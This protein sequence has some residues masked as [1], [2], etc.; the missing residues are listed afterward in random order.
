MGESIVTEV[1]HSF[2]IVGEPRSKERPRLNRRTG[3]VY[4]PAATVNAE[5]EVAAAFGHRVPFDSAVAVDLRFYCFSKTRRDLDNLVKLVLD[6]L[7]GIA[8]TD[9]YQVVRITARR[10]QVD[11]VEQARTTVTVSTDRDNERHTNE[12]WKTIA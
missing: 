5:R 10:V 7:N 2:V 9:D 11:A 4:T 8:Y 12:D 3:G 6:G 1:Y